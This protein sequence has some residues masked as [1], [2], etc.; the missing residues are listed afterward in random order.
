MAPPWFRLVTFDID[1]TLTLQHGWEAIA[2]ALGRADQYAHVMDQFRTGRVSEDV[3]INRLLN[4][5][6]G[7][8]VAEVQA[9][10]AATP[11]LAR[12]ADGV[13]L[14][15]EAGVRVGLLT[16]NPDYVTRW[17]RSEFGFDDAGGL[18]GAQEEGPPIGPAV[19]LRAD[20]PAG[21]AQMLARYPAP[22]DTVVH[23][24]DA[25]PDAWMFPRVGGGVA[26]NAKSVAVE[27]AADLSLR[28]ADCLEV[29]TAVLRMPR[30][31]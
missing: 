1:G 2:S 28:S 15:H 6:A 5:A 22:P 30:R 10:V 24:G 19:G 4:L 29:A 27:E 16:H 21:L 23:V 3:Q 14:L 26:L 25:S 17:Y 8:T 18:V 20:K 7:H 11:K 12:I 31:P 9:A 13:R